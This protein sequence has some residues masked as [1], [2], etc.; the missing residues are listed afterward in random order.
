MVGK[1]KI[2]NTGK[3]INIAKIA[4][5]SAFDKKISSIA[6]QQ[7]SFNK[8]IENIVRPSALNEA[9]QSINSQHSSFSKAIAAIATPSI[10]DK[11]IRIF[12]ENSNILMADATC[13]SAI[14][15]VVSNIDIEMDVSNIDFNN[16]DNTTEQFAYSGDGEHRFWPS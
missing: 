16:Y 5:L 11:A 13:I 3:T 6:F 7:T 15:R 12:Y 2:K 1:S 8:A 9:L 4:N 10:I 14:S